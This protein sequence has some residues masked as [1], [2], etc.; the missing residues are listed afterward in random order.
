[1]EKPNL[2]MQDFHRI[3]DSLEEVSR[4]VAE[5][6]GGMD[7]LTEEQFGCAVFVLMH[8]MSLARSAVRRMCVLS[9]C[10]ISELDLACDARNAKA[11]IFGAVVKASTVKQARTYLVYKALEPFGA[12]S[13][14]VVPFQR[15]KEPC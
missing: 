13:G 11:A 8:G 12:T 4:V 15:P 1:M 7:L 6:T 3:A 2:T 5:Y 14:R 9:G 10:D